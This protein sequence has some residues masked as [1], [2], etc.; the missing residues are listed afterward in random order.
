[1]S[2]RTPRN[3]GAYRRVTVEATPFALTE[4]HAIIKASQ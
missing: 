2:Q 1:M 4:S 3:I